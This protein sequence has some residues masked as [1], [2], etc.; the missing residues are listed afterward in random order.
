MKKTQGP[1]VMQLVAAAAKKIG[2]TVNIEPTW[3]YVGQIIFKNGKKCYFRNTSL[4]LNP[5]GASEIARDKA[6]ASYFLAELGYPVVEEKIFY[7]KMWSKAIKSK[8]GIDQ[9]YAYA[10]KLGFP[11]IV[12]P[13]S[14]SQGSGVAKVSTRAEFYKAARSIFRGDKVMI[15][16]R[17]FIGK[18]Y[19]IVV[20]DNTVISAYERNPLSVIGDGKS[21]LKKLL[22]EKQAEFERQKRDTQ[23]KFDDQRILTTLFRNK[24]TFKTVLEKGHKMSLL[25]NANLSTGGTS[26]D[27]TD[28]MHQDFKDIAIAVTKDMGLRLCGVD[29]MITGGIEDSHSVKNF[30]CVLEINSAPGLD[31]YYASGKKQKKIVEDIYLKIVV[32]MEK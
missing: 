20:L 25:D 15:V 11:V 24:M 19:R 1:F 32:A 21:T 26:K 13:N 6:Y 28:T 9:A 27:V 17:L 30:Y 23:I 3:H 29:L 16:Q 14:K 12:K 18:D 5:M 2:A 10:K 8:L 22:I 4:D 7:S 31:H